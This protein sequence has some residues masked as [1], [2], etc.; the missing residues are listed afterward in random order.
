MKYSEEKYPLQQET[1]Q[2]IGICMEV[3]SI[4]GLG[5]LEVVY[6]DAIEYELKLKNILY[7]REKK[8]QVR[9]KDV[10]FQR[11]FNADFVIFDKILL[12]VKAQKEIADEHYKW[13]LNYMNLSN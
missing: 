3:H 10:I 1:Y 6:K 4:L 2:I 13:V 5:L 7:E 12:E 8:Y 9:Y 11:Y